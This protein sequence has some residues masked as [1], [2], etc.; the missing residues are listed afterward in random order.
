MYLAPLVDDLK[1]LWDTGVEVYDAYRQENFTL[2][3][4]LLWTIN[5][6]PT[7]GNLSACTTKGY[8]ACPVCHYRI[9]SKR[10][11]HGR[12]CTYGGHRKYLPKDHKFRK[13]KKLFD[14]HEEHRQPPIPLTGDEIL[15]WVVDVN[16]LDT[17]QEELV[18]TLCLLENY[19]LPTFFDVMVHLTVHLIREVKLC[20]PVWYH[21]MYPFERYMKVLKGYV[22]NGSKPEGCIA[23]CYIA[24]EALEF[25]AEHLQ[26]MS[27]V[28]VPTNTNNQIRN[29]A[30]GHGI[31]SADAAYDLDPRMKKAILSSTGEKWRQFKSSLAVNEILPNRDNLAMLKRPPKLY[32]FIFQKDWESFVAIRL[33]GKYMKMHE[34]AVARVREKKYQ[35]RLGRNGYVERHELW[36]I[37]QRKK[38]GEY[39]NDVVREIAEKIVSY[40]F[41]LTN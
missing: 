38:N 11:L 12:K 15:R 20:G 39:A 19:F 16:N 29:A 28:G 27:T 4:V 7:Y 14:G 25:C 1:L 32:N 22:R 21:W 23:E 36:K 30:L 26:N 33:S 24:E 40:A 37:A 10:L 35:Y 9:D 2:K 34:E 13:Q 31:G 8:K 18:T 17:I 41:P 3:V 5:D 6:F